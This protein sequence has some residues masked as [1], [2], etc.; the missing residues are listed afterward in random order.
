MGAIITKLQNLFDNFNIETNDNDNHRASPLI[1][2]GGLSNVA[3]G[4]P[5]LTIHIKYLSIPLSCFVFLCSY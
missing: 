3:S 2:L 1:Y 4:R 5:S